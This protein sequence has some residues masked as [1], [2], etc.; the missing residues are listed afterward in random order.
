MESDMPQGITTGYVMLG[1]I[2]SFLPASR[3]GDLRDIILE[4]MTV[5]QTRLT[6]MNQELLVACLLFKGGSSPSFAPSLLMSRK[7]SR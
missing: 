3:V 4:T 2:T 1:A 6:A 5:F 7:S